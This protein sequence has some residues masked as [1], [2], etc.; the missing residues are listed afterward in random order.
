MSFIHDNKIEEKSFSN[1]VESKSILEIEIRTPFVISV[2]L[3]KGCNMQNIPQ[4]EHIKIPE[5][6][7]YAEKWLRSYE[8]ANK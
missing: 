2:S 7:D 4:D 5:I 6:K 1:M 8:E 3:A